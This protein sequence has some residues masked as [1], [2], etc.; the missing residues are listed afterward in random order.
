MP[1]VFHGD[2]S[3]ENFKILIN[4]PTGLSV[5]CTHYTVSQ[6]TWGRIIQND[7][8]DSQIFSFFLHVFSS[9]LLSQFPLDIL[10]AIQ[11]ILTHVYAL[12]SILARQLDFFG[13]QTQASFA[14]TMP[15]SA[16]F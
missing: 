3:V 13:P 1:F 2:M 11:G 7:L 15:I 6:Y 9:F 5:A 14:M 16:Q 10:P 12:S 4:I 8:I